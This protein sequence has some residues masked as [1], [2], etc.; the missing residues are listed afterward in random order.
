MIGIAFRLSVI[1]RM[2][3][4]FE[5]MMFKNITC[6][7]FTIIIQYSVKKQIDDF[8]TSKTRNTYFCE[9]DA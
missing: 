3:I 5:F 6:T 1:K 4:C 7:R 8:E 2:S 9:S